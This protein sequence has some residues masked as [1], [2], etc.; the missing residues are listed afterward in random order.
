[1]KRSFL[2]LALC[3]LCA[4]AAQ[5]PIRANQLVIPNPYPDVTS[6]SP[7]SAKAGSRNIVLTIHG[8]NFIDGATVSFGADPLRPRLVSGTQITVVVPA[9][10][11]VRPGSRLVSVT[12]PPPGG[13]TRAAVTPFRVTATPPPKPEPPPPPPPPTP[14]PDVPNR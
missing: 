3:C 6:F 12:N 8:S 13:G 2:G 1:V 14:H 9:S 5:L 4:I 7:K 10:A 11:L